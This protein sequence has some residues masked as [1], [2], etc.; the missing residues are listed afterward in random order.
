MSLDPR[1][2]REEREAERA[3][4]QSAAVPPL[5]PPFPYRKA[6]FAPFFFGVHTE[7]P[8]TTEEENGS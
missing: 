6:T 4:E 8:E 2:N 1:T 7:P 3:A 5:N